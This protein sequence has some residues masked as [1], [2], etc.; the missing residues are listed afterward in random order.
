MSEHFTGRRNRLQSVERNPAEYEAASREAIVD[1]VRRMEHAWNIA[2]GS[3]YAAA[4]TEDSDYVAFDGTHLRGRD[5]NA[6]HHQRLFNSLLK[7][8]RLVFEGTPRVRF[9][10][11]GVAVVHAMGSVLFPWQSRVTAKRRSNQTLVAVRR[12]EG[13]RF[14]AFHNTRYR[15]TALPTGMPLKLI[16]ALMRVRAALS[17]KRAR[18][19]A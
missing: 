5:A 9:L 2:D 17:R 16:L 8:T 15:P 3:A 18:R 10:A 4:F 7:N 13:W 11:E 19:A 6:R 1:L 12:P 14:T